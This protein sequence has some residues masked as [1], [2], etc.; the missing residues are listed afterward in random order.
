M[1][2]CTRWEPCSAASATMLC[3][4]TLY[5][6]DSPRISFWP[7][8]SQAFFN[9]RTMS[10]ARVVI[11]RIGAP[12]AILPV[13]AMRCSNAAGLPLATALAS[14]FL[15]KLISA[16]SARQLPL[17]HGNFYI[18]PKYPET[19]VEVEAPRPGGWLGPG[20]RKRTCYLAR[21]APCEIP[22]CCCANRAP[23]I[24]HRAKWSPASR[25]HGASRHR[26]M[27]PTCS[28]RTQRSEPV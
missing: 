12:L 5:L 3:A 20:R 1:M 8:L 4:S 14:S 15:L 7:S 28:A 6:S 21:C 16:S 24:A 2:M 26:A 13:F 17:V 11:D 22:R 18:A 25:P 23:R 19:V 10:L 27:Q 9:R